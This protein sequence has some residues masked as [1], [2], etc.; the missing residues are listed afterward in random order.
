[1]GLINDEKEIEEVA[2]SVDSS[3]NVYF[4]PSFGGLFSPYW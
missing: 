2:K 4:V 3:E 1:M